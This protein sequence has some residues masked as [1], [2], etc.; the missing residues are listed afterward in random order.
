[1]PWRGEIGIGETGQACRGAGAVR[2]VCAPLLLVLT[3]GAAA[4]AVLAARAA[5]PAR[6]AVPLPRAA[7]P[8]RLT[9]GG[10]VAV[11]PARPYTLNRIAAAVAGAESSYGTN[12]AMWRADDP[13]GPQGPMQ[14]SAAAATDVGGGNRFNINDNWVLGRAYLA[15]MYHRYGSWTD[16]V[17]AYNWGP[18]NV[19]AWIASGRR[20]NQLPAAVERYTG[21]VLLS[22]S[23]VQP[24]GFVLRR[25]GLRARPFR[26][27]HILPINPHDPVQRLYTAIMRASLRNTR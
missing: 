15:R 19:D 9:T 27:R 17:A 18:G 12:P 3:H 1:M 14:V 8:M 26:P 13:L 2:L 20:A 21:E 5:W 4:G 6:I 10:A 24:A 23:G 16:A 11:F 25:P 7:G 22:A